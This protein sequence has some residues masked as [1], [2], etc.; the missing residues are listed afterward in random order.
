MTDSMQ[1]VTAESANVTVADICK[2]SRE[3]LT[4]YKIP[5]EVVF[6]GELPKSSVGKILCWEL[7]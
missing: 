5:R 6:M 7:R 3:P 4:N 1:T 2:F